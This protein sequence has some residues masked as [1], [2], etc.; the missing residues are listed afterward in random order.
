MTFVVLRLPGVAQDA[1]EADVAHVQRDLLALKRLLEG[2]RT[3]T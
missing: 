1:F 2:R 3:V